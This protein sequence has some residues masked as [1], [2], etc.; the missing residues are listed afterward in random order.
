MPD[1]IE[2]SNPT[3]QIR[4]VLDDLRR[5]EGD[6]EVHGPLRTH[7]DVYVKCAMATQLEEKGNLMHTEEV[8]GS[9]VNEPDLEAEYERVC[10][11]RS[12]RISHLEEIKARIDEMWDEEW[13]P[14]KW[15]E[16]DSIYQALA[17]IF[18]E[19]KR[20]QMLSLLNKGKLVVVEEEEEDL[21]DEELFRADL[22]T[23]TMISR[24]KTTMLKG[25]IFQE[26]R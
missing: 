2:S 9:F 11:H 6:E 18:I 22:Q 24:V 25:G 26:N 1:V 3:S 12:W 14:L 23:A 8:V 13:F 10:L 17:Q 4:G 21:V 20:A 15:L 5:H 16:A 19:E 7:I